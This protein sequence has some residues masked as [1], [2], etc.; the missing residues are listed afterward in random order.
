MRRHLSNSQTRY[1]RL[2]EQAE[3]GGQNG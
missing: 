3:V 2:A 1:R